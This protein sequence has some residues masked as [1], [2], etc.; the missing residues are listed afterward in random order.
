MIFADYEATQ[1]EVI[2]FSSVIKFQGNCK[3]T[4]TKN[5]AMEYGGVIHS[6]VNSLVVFDGYAKINFQRNSAKGGGVVYLY[7][8]FITS[9][10]KSNVIFKNNSAQTGGAIYISQSNITFVGNSS[11]QFIKN[12]FSQSNITFVGNSSVQFI[13]NTAIQDGGAIYLS[14]HSI[15]TLTNNIKVK[16]SDNF[17]NDDGKAIYVQIKHS[18]LIFNI[19]KFHF[20]DNNLGTTRNLIYLNVPKLCNRSCLLQ[21]VIKFPENI[22]LPIS[23]SPRRLIIYDPAKCIDRNNSNMYSNIY[24]INNVMLD[25]KSG[26][27]HVY[28]TITISQLN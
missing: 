25:K 21:R 5:K 3:I 19:T 7:K 13:K 26:L 17:A 8:S 18:L 9:R 2:Q 1:G 20:S 23:T 16:F 15:F 12:T 24:Y 10:L 22:S 28:W 4:F 14:D 6:S 27:M 11:V